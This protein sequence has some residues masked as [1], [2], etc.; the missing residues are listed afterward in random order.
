MDAG[1]IFTIEYESRVHIPYKIWTRR[2]HI[3]LQNMD[4]PHI[5]L[6]QVGSIF[7]GGP[8]PICLI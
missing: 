4:P 6:T 2:V 3:L 5:I 1:S 7:Y 8:Y